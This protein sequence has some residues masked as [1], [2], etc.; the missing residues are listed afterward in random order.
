MNNGGYSS[1]VVAPGCDPGR[2]RFDSDYSPQIHLTVNSFTVI[3][4]LSPGG[5]MAD[6]LVLDSSIFGCESSSLS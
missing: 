1:V 3:I 2:R 5:E 4:L 6:T